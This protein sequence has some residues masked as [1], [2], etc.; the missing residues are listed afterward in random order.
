MIGF[1]ALGIALG[2]CCYMWRFY[3]TK[4]FANDLDYKLLT[5]II[6]AEV[7][8]KLKELPNSLH[9][10]AMG[11]LLAMVLLP[12]IQIFLDTTDKESCQLCLQ[13]IWFCICV[14]TVSG[15]LLVF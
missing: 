4:R 1:L 15:M 5:F 3:P 9:A 14:A 11:A 7:C 10:V 8:F 6:L 12:I 13:T 2:L